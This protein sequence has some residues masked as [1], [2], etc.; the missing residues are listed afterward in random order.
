MATCKLNP[1]QLAEE[2]EDND[3]TA[4]LFMI[5]GISIAATYLAAGGDISILSIPG[6][7]LAALVALLKATQERRQWT[8]KGIV[9]IGTSVIGSTLPSGLIHVIWPDWVVKLTWH[10]FLLAGFLFGL[11]G[12]MLGWAIILALDA[13]REKIAKKVVGVGEKRLGLDSDSKS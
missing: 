5:G 7:M 8:D 1:R 13:R 2:Q 4:E 9:V 12:W 3:M 6:A 11:V 10:V